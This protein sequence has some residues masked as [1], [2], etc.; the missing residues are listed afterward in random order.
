MIHP[1]QAPDIPALLA[2]LDRHAVRFVITGSVAARLHGVELQ[3]GDLDVVPA[4]DTANLERLVAVLRELEARPPGPFGAWTTLPNGEQKWIPRPT[5]PE[6]VAAWTPDVEDES[7]LDHLYRTRLGDFD[8]VPRV[9]GTYAELK[10][11]AVRLPAFGHT[12]W[13]A[14]V[15]DLLARLTVPRREKDAPRVARLREIQ[16]P[17]RS[18][19]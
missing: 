1:S 16:R 5:T 18:A 3:P 10:P 13:V 2:L 7:S 14:H 11:R 8:V 19:T 9:T 15:D 4:L 12:P 17:G 6:E